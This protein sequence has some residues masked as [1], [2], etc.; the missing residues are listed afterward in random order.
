MRMKYRTETAEV[1]AKIHTED[2]NMCLLVN[3]TLVHVL[4]GKN[5]KVPK[6]F[7]I[8]NNAVIT[9]NK[10]QRRIYINDLDDTV[11]LGSNKEFTIK[12]S[13]EIPLLPISIPKFIRDTLIKISVTPYFSCD[14]WINGSP[15]TI[16]IHTKER[17]EGN[18]RQR[19]IFKEKIMESIPDG[20]YTTIPP[21]CPY[22]GNCISDFPDTVHISNDGK[23]V[24][25][26][27]IDMTEIRKMI[28]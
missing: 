8:P 15:R 23:Q 7:I 26:F 17:F 2:Q 4:N 16:T 19:E 22:Y 14:C 11:K 12:L 1:R 27:E 20:E 18:A 28:N 24:T 13:I 21:F 25:E 6:T 5:I 3:D 10:N 9:L